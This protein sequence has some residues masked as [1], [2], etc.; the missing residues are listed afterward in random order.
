MF[1]AQLTHSAF[2][3]ERRFWNRGKLPEQTPLVFFFFENGE[4]CNLIHLPA[5]GKHHSFSKVSFI[6]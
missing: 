4:G 1:C 5:N 3:V 6:T 2:G